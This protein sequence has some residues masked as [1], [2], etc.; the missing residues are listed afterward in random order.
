MEGADLRQ[1]STPGGPGDASQRWGH[2]SRR[3]LAG[4]LLKRPPVPRLYPSLPCPPP[5]RSVFWLGATHCQLSSSVWKAGSCRTPE[6]G[7]VWKGVQADRKTE[8]EVER[9]G[10]RELGVWACVCACH[11]CTCVSGH[12]CVSVCTC[13]HVRICVC[14]CVHARVSMC[15]CVSVYWTGA[16]AF[17]KASEAHP[18][19]LST[20]KLFAQEIR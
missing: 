3:V 6:P 16:E 19:W 7:P 15:M 5:P 14:M 12:E 17:Y 11:V 1:T 9:P 8:H 20:A 2:P 10:P 4:F 13:V 18:R